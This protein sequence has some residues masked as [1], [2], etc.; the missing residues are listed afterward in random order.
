MASL[1]KNIIDEGKQYYK[2]GIWL[3]LV[4]VIVLLSV[5]FTLTFRTTLINPHFS[6]VICYLFI[7][8]LLEEVAR[9]L[10][11]K[12]HFTI[13]FFIFFSISEIHY[14]AYMLEY[15]TMLDF[16]LVRLPAFIMH[17]TNTLLQK[18]FY[19]KSQRINCTCY[20]AFAF[21]VTVLI[22]ICFNNAVYSMMPF[23]VINK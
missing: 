4:L 12:Y 23:W 8:P 20:F 2:K 17:T 22:H 6:F 19:D 5:N 11:V 10:S 16:I 9:L 21:V 3:A 13:W 18:Y 7:G 1:L 14:Y 15:M